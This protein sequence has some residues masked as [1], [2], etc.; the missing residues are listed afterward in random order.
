[1]LCPGTRLANCFFATASACD[2]PAAGRQHPG[3][4]TGWSQQIGWSNGQLP[5]NSQQIG[6]NVG[7][8][9]PALV[10]GGQHSGWSGGQ[11]PSLA[12]RVGSGQQLHPGS[13]QLCS[14]LTP[15]GQQ[16]IPVGQQPPPREG[17]Q[18]S[19]PPGQ[20]SPPNWLCEQHCMFWSQVASL[21]SRAMPST[22]MPS[23][24]VPR[25]PARVAG[26]KYEK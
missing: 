7:Q 17:G 19:D 3:P 26:S 22:E 9:P 14:P 8:H 4:K 18:Q 20:Q 5:G 10:S 12:C 6:A 11:Q 16:A 13:Q 15:G 25:S 2:R 23:W 1:W 21:V 24:L